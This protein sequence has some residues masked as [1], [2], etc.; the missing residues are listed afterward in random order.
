M[1]TIFKPTTS[2]VMKSGWSLSIY[3]GKFSHLI[4]A[5]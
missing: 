4:I 1:E 2:R 5:Q 3:E